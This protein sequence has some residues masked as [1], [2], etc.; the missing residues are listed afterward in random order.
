[1]KH[2]L[3]AGLLCAV[4]LTTSVYSVTGMA[5]AASTAVTAQLRPNVTVQIDGTARTFY[6]AQGQEVYPIIYNGS[7]YLPLRSIGEL[8]NKNVNWNSSTNTVTVS[9]VRTAGGVVGIPNHT[10]KQMDVTFYLR[11][12]I[13]VVIDGTV[14]TFYSSDGK[15]VSP[16]VYNGSIYLPIR[17]IGEIMG[18]SVFWDGRT[19]TVVL[20]AN[21]NDNVTDYDTNNGVIV[22][23]PATKP[24]IPENET[25]VTLEK[26]KQIALKH[27]GKTASQVTFVK[28][29]KDFDDGRWEYEIEFI[30]SSKNGYLEYDYEIDAMTGKILSCDYDAES[31]TPDTNGNAAQP[32]VSETAAKKTALARVPGATAANLCEFKLEHDDGRWEYEGKIVYKQME[33]EFT[34]DASTGAIVEWEA[35]SIYD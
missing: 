5:S 23:P 31:Y 1:M 22:V 34:I 35:E 33:Y 16:A 3:I 12:E 28:A 30:V 7:T 25:A 15:Q 29:Q 8:M 13:T 10:A 9:G 18:K 19:Q 17:S 32:A 14:R 6:N 2:K 27:A 24:S 21:L 4:V 20:S 11:P 26:A